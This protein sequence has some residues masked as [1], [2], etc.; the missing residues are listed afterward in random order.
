MSRDKSLLLFF[1][2]I[3][4]VL[5]QQTCAAKINQTCPP[6]SCGK[7]R[8][9]KHPFRL[10][11]D[12]ATCGDPRYELSCENNTTTLTLF[13]GKYYVKSINY[14][15]YTIRLVDPGIQE[16]DCST[17]PRYFL[18]ASNFTSY[19]NYSYHR[20]LYEVA[21]QSGFGYI[22]YLNCSKP[23]KNNPMFVN[24]ARC[25]KWHNK[26]HV[27]AIAGD[28]N[29]GSLNDDCHVKLVTMSSASVLFQNHYFIDTRQNFTYSE[30]HE[31]LSYGFDLTWMRR[32]CEDSCGSNQQNLH[33]YFN[34]DTGDLK[35]QFDYC[36]TPLGF[37]I[38]CGKY[39]FIFSF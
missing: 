3:V 24:T 11:N 32:A 7:I 16:G 4:V 20:D 14:N 17:I 21:E 12:P 2:Q 27:Y 35:C 15:N 1:F 10:K 33:C 6:S 5:L 39:K 26:G 38:R 34:Q 13:S 25:I 31:M 36:T 22:I 8:D 30:I 28:I 37:N 23:V 18:S 29:T 9:I 19:Y